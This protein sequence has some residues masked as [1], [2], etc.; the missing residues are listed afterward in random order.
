LEPSGSWIEMFDMF[1][2]S[3]KQKSATL[4]ALHLGC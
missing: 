1:L 2:N 3:R 4:A